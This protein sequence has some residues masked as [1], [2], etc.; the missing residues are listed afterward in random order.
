MS[1]AGP[2]GFQ[3]IRLLDVELA[4]PIPEIAAGAES[5][6]VPFPSGRYERA[7]TLVRLHGRPLG[8]VP[9]ACP[10]GWLAAKRLAAAI[11]EEL[12]PSINAHLREDGLLQLSELNEEGVAPAGSTPRCLAWREP[13]LAAAPFVSIVIPTRDRAAG[14]DATLRSM[15]ALAYPRFEIVVVDNAPRTDATRRVVASFAGTDSSVRARCVREDRPGISWAK[16]RGLLEADGEIVAF[17]DDDVIVDPHWLTE[18]VRGFSAGEN[19]ACVTGMITPLE[20]ETPAQILIERFGGFSKGFSRRVFDL[21]RHH[22]GGRLYPYTAGIFGSGANM[23]FRTEV[24]RAL[25]GFDPALGAGGPAMGGEDLAI[26]FKVVMSGYQIAYEPAALIRHSHHREYA[27]L[28]RQIYCYGVG[29]AAYLVETVFERPDLLPGLLLRLPGGI[30]YA[31]S[32]SSEK[33]RNKRRASVWPPYPRELTI[34][35]LRGMLVGP[36]AY[37]RGRRRSRA[38][39]ARPSTATGAGESRTPADGS[40]PASELPA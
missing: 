10:G 35:E 17:T 2:N 9:V 27:T 18:L 28:R 14:L 31:L 3:P 20:L 34:D 26:C 36:I 23:A 8:T 29:L 25:G 24:L 21:D 19:V 4:G 7:L 30:S 11:W 15:L 16:N 40:R 37:L 38:L 22:P 39:A 33:N 13:L 12:G 5:S 6:G 1:D 32:A